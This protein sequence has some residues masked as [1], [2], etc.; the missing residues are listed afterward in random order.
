MRIG[1]IVLHNDGQTER[2][3]IVTHIHGDDD[4]PTADVVTFGGGTGAA[5]VTSVPHLSNRGEDGPY[6]R[7]HHEG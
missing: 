7:H 1:D 3:A 2:P 4:N 5:E 6:Y